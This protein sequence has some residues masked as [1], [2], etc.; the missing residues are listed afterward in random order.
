MRAGAVLATVAEWL[1]LRELVT[2]HMRIQK[3]ATADIPRGNAAG[4]IGHVEVGQRR[5]RNSDAFPVRRLPP[6]HDGRVVAHARFLPFLDV[7][8]SNNSP[9]SMSRTSQSASQTSLSINRTR[10]CW[11]E[12]R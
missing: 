9:G 2:P 7:S 10:P 4:T 6:D 3:R 11:R 12:S 1:V 8:S 5:Q